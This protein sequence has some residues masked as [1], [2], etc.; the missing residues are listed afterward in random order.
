MTPAEHYAAG[1]QHLARADQ[2]VNDPTNGA[3]TAALV[4]AVAHFTAA[5]AGELGVPVGSTHVAGLSEPVTY[6]PGQT[7]PG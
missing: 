6:A 3:T 1:E 4:M 2:I 7:P 5:I